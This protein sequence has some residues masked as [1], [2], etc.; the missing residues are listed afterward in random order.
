MGR[1]GSSRS[2]SDLRPLVRLC[3]IRK[4]LVPFFRALCA[5]SF[6]FLNGQR[7]SNYVHK[8]ILVGIQGRKVM[9]VQ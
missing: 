8:C 1:E 3:S 9:H 2:A 6:L 4:V 5:C 7:Y